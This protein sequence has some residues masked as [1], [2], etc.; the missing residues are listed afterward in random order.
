M[1]NDHLKDLIKNLPPKPGV[2]KFLNSSNKIIYIGKAKN[3]KKRV[4]SYFNRNIKD[5]KTN[6]LVSKINTFSIV[7]VKSETDALLLENNLI[8]KFKPKY[9]ILLKDGKSYPWICVKNER[10]P[11]IFLTRKVIDDGSSYFG[12]Y[13]NIKT[14]YTLLELIDN[15]FPIRKS[16]YNFSEKIIN[17]PKNTFYLNVLRK[18]GHFIITGFDMQNI[19]CDKNII[20]EKEYS[21]IILAVKNILQGKFKKSRDKIKLQMKNYSKNE[22]FEL[23]EECKMKIMALENYQSKSTI[24]N[25]KIKNLDIYT[26]ISDS[27]HAFINYIQVNNGSIICSFNTNVKK[28]SIIDEKQILEQL[29][30]QIK[31]KFK[32]SSNE[33]CSNINIETL[34]YKKAYVPLVGDKSHLVKLSLLNIKNYKLKEFNNLNNRLNTSP[35]FRV[36]SRL[37][38]DLSL[39]ELPTHIECFDNSNFQGSYPSSACV[40]FKNGKPLKTEYRHFNIKSVEKP[41]DF[42]SMEEVVFR[43]YKRLIN[44]KKKLPQLVVIDGGKGQLT[45]ALK[46]LKKL[47]LDKKIKCIGIAKRLEEIYFPFESTPIYIDKKSE[48]LKLI[49]KLRDEAHRFSLRQHRNRR[50]KIFLNSELDEIHGIGKKTIALLIKNFKSVNNIKKTNIDKLSDVVG[51]KKAAFISNYFLSQN[52]K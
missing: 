3:L 48:S 52:E 17:D 31:L 21:E 32:S 4:S 35:Q 36:L 9:N 28:Q 40:V 19:E 7:L 26:I 47:K 51:S 18:K 8:K 33:M 1:T 46:S 2:Y 13:T 42:A 43:R 29:V 34:S 6:T 44:E 39:P 15:L 11:R 23:A 22:E 10:F 20:T 16:N 27:S 30:S 24:V 38:D 25:P 50:D 45:S 5:E 37:K 14:A 12:P 41:D 49:Q